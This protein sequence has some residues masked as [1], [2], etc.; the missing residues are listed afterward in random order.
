MK[1]MAV[2]RACKPIPSKRKDSS[3]IPVCRSAGQMGKAGRIRW[4]KPGESDQS[5]FDEEC[6]YMSKETKGIFNG[7]VKR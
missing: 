5:E 1:R 6:E 3:E 2:K 7:E 4:K